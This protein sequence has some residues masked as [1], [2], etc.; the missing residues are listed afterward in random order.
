MN[1]TDLIQTS[2]RSTTEEE[3]IELLLR[4]K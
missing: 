2:C 1:E 3:D 4:W